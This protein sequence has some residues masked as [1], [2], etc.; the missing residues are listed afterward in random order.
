MGAGSVAARPGIAGGKGTL[1][2][3]PTKKIP[4]RSAAISPHPDA[5]ARRAAR[6]LSPRAP[7][8][9]DPLAAAS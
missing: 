5:A 6:A 3:S 9:A 8:Q 7:E 1:L 2:I 4:S